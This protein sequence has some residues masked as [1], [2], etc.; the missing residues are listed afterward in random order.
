M[1]LISNDDNTVIVE[2]D[3]GVRLS[4][5]VSVYD[6]TRLPTVD[7]VFDEINDFFQQRLKPEQRKNIFEV[8]VKIREA[9]QIVA[10]PNALSKILITMVGEL[11]K[12]IDFEEFEFWYKWKCVDR[13][14]IPGNLKV[15]YDPDDPPERTYLKAD[16]VKLVGLAVLLRPMIPIWGEYILRIKDQAGNVYKEYAAMRL[17][18]Q[19]PL[20]LEME[21]MEKL[22]VYVQKS[23]GNDQKTMSAIFSGL[24]TSELPEYLLALVVVRRLVVGEVHAS[25]ERGNVISNIYGFLTG[26][27]KDLDRRFGGGISEKHREDDSIDDDSMSLVESYKVKAEVP[28][29]EIA[30]LSMYTKNVVL[31]AKTIDPTVDEKMVLACVKQTLRN[32]EIE[33]QKFQ[34]VLCQWLIKPAMSPM[35]L[36]HLNKEPFLRVMGVCQALLWHWGFFNLAALLT[37]KIYNLPENTMFA[38]ETRLRIPNNQVDRLL[39]LY[40]HYHPADERKVGDDSYI[41]RN[42]TGCKAVRA[43]AKEISGKVYQVTCLDDLTANCQS[44]DGTGRMP[45]PGDL[46]ESVANLA[47]TIAE[48]KQ[49]YENH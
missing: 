15:Q 27:L 21:A 5:D 17:M 23:V 44:V 1:R 48:G 7:G 10:E 4:W 49:R 47:I 9:L 45:A 12:A 3:D 6:R 11:Y 46:A 30:V 2:S 28:A 18:G 19:V 20:V 16:Y 26:A 8:Y 41:R 25:E 42:N 38:A 24:G 43:L 32:H 22:R 34:V 35:G 40:P 36:T 37:A 31:M 14:I 13:I 39:Q 33:I 29:G